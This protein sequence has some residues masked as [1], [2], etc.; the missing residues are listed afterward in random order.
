MQR[1]GR[2]ISDVPGGQGRIQAQAGELMTMMGA[3]M[4]DEDFA[5]FTDAISRSC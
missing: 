2:I 3:S 4:N 1:A 5:T